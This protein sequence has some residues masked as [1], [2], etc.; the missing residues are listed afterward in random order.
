VAETIN[1]KPVKKPKLDADQV[2]RWLSD[3]SDQQFIAL[4]YA[5]LSDRNIYRAERRYCDSKLVL[6]NAKRHR[7]DDGTTEAWLLELLCPTPGTNWA[8]DAPV[9]QFG[10]CCDH[11]TASVARLSQCPICANEVSGT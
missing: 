10:H 8:A 1:G 11:P 2:A 4:F 7:E 9:C 5:Q 6:A 3:L